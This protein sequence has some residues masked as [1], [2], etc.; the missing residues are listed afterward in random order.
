MQT[1][2]ESQ[3]LS[4]LDAVRL[5]AALCIV[6]LHSF[7]EKNDFMNIYG[8][9]IIG[10]WPVG[11][12][13]IISGFFLSFNSKDVFAYCFK[14]LRVY[15]IWTVFY[16]VW[17]NLDIWS[18]MHFLSALR[19]GIIMPFW[20]F[21]SLLMCVVFVFFLFTFTKDLRIVCFITGLMFIIAL[22]GCSFRFVP[23]ISEFMDRFFFPWHERLIGVHHMRNGIFN[24]S[25]YIALGALLRKR[26]DV[27][28]LKIKNVRF[29]CIALCFTI[30]LHITE[31]C[32]VIHFHTGEPD[33]LLTSP[34]MA[35]L[36]ILFS[37][38]F[39]M[40]KDR[41]ILC[42]GMSNLVFLSHCFFIDV[43]QRI[44]FGQ[45]A[46]FTLTVC[47]SLLFSYTVVIHSKKI[48]PLR[49]LY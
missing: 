2:F 22:L 49:Y 29:I 24:G 43:F 4:I 16:A 26:Y 10:R 47:C 8:A 20:Y 34:L 35:A 6:V 23:A 17:L 14:I 44:G 13:F 18:P 21:P 27:D 48:S 41:A 39:T 32:F 7:L 37:F 33:V 11:L 12:F 1:E 31:I 36:L 45:W 38:Q 46:V 15:I 5:I 3:K 42:R 25:F 40:P 28:Q 19:S 30:I 9:E